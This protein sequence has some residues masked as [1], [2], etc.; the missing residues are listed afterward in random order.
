MEEGKSRKSVKVKNP[1]KICT[2][3]V[4]QK[5]G[6]Q[7]NG[8]CKKWMH[9]T[10]LKY[11][12]GKIQDIKDGFIKV[13]CPCPDCEG[14]GPKEEIISKPPYKCDKSCCPT[15]EAPTCD[16][17]ECPVNV[18]LAAKQN[19][20][21]QCE[22]P[23]ACAL[24]KGIVPQTQT[25]LYPPQ[26]GAPPMPLN[27]QPPGQQNQA[28]CP[29]SACQS[30]WQPNAEN[31]LNPGQPF[32]SNQPYAQNQ[33]GPQ[34]GNQPYPQAQ[35]IL[36][37][38]YQPLSVSQ[39]PCPPCPMAS[40]QA[41]PQQPGLQSFCPPPQ[42]TAAQ[43]SLPEKGQSA[44]NLKDGSLYANLDEMCKTVGLLTAQ[45]R[46]LMCKLVK[47]TEESKQKCETE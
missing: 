30:T 36:Q 44:T 24:L 23:P 7:C 9:Y 31:Q 26:F 16:S 20:D 21:M 22:V 28:M 40:N 47:H 13:I 19:G 45:I 27:M 8:A 41:M 12:P 10:C 4:N 37:Q 46:Q 33:C 6:I 39:Q 35:P 42:Q 43:T 29:T 34:F 17:S 18:H 38:Q 14:S 3:T 2:T 5:T 11:T 15:K 1:C 25:P 32:S